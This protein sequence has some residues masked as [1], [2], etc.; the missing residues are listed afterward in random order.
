MKDLHKDNPQYKLIFESKVHGIKFYMPVDNG[1]YHMS[2]YIAAGQ[3]NI[4][5]SLGA[6]R[7]YLDGLTQKM[8]DLCNNENNKDRLRTDMAVLANNLRYRLQYPVDED[9]S[10]RMGAIYAIAQ[11]EHADIHD[12]FQTQ[13]KVDLAKGNQTHHISPDPDLYAFFLSMGLQATESWTKY[14]PTTTGNGYFQKRLSDLENL[15][16]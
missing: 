10:I 15:M 14:E 1:G 4:Y 2:R 12:N 8:L 13:R 6:T 9:C 11:D 7:E 5:S 3:Q 16:P